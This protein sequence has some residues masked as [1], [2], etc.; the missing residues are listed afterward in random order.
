MTSRGPACDCF[1]SSG[2]DEIDGFV[3][4]ARWDAGENAEC[5][6]LTLQLD[7]RD[8]VCRHAVAEMMTLADWERV[9]AE[10]EAGGAVLAEAPRG[11]VIVQLREASARSLASGGSTALGYLAWPEF[12]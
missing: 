2:S 8:G 12:L 11:E 4:L 3:V 6:V 10:F 9:L 7:P 1:R 5:D